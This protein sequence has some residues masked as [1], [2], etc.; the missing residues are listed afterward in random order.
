MGEHRHGHGAPHGHAHAFA[1]ADALTSVLDDPARDEWQ[2]PEQ[3]LKALELE[4]TMVVADVGAGTGYFS[5]RL[6]RALPRGKVI[7]TDLSPDMVRFLTDRARREGLENLHA[8]L[9]TKHASGLAVGSSDRILV[10]HAWHH[11]GDRLGAARSLADSLRTN[12][13]LLVVD[14]TLTAPRGP[15]AELRVTPDMVIAELKSAGL[16]A[17]RLPVEIADQFLIEARR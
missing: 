8:V 3:V 16:T 5:V 10:V 2:Q 1:D 7:A 17:A 6:A 14:F 13:R 11:L 4:P 12:G 9:A 15:P